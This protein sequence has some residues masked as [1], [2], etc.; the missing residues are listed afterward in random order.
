MVASQ[1]KAAARAAEE[2]VRPQPQRFRVNVPAA[3]EAVL[4]WMEAQYNHSLSVRLLIRESIERHGYVDAMNRPVEQLPKRGRPAVADDEAATEPL[5]RH[6]QTP[7]PVSLPQSPPAAA[8][9]VPLPAG[10]LDLD[11]AEGQESGPELLGIALQTPALVPAPAQQD[12]APAVT[13]P[14]LDGP[15]PASSEQVDVNDIFSSIR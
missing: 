3:D 14:A 8:P 7:A 4:A 13:I 12:P 2:A 1:G 10:L 11:R 5:V 6:A 9:A 15:E